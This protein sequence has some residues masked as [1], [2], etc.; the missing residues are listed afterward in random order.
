MAAETA[1]IQGVDLW[2]EQRTR[3]AAGLEFHSKYELGAAVPSWLCGGVVST[4]SSPYWEEA[5]NAL[6]NRLGVPLPYTGRLLASRRPATTD[7]HYSGWE[8]LP[9]FGNL[10]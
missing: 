6:H 1:R 8:T 7:H 5:Y 2:A 4:A 10:A 3:F 9:F